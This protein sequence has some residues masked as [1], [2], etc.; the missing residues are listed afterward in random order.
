MV[1]SSGKETNS[2][3]LLDRVPSK[4]CKL[5]L[6]RNRYYDDISGNYAMLSSRIAKDSGM[7][8]LAVDY[9][10]TDSNNPHRFPEA[11]HDV[12]DGFEWL[13]SMGASE[14]YLYGACVFALESLPSR[15]W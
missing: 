6:W 7:G 15:C 11:I 3:F 13:K 14:L 5:N 4:T 9:R 8:V 12:I 2:W 1:A 10:T